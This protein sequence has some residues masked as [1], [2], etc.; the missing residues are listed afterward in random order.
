MDLLRLRRAG[1][2]TAVLAATSCFL[3]L[4]S[5]PM[6]CAEEAGGETLHARIQEAIRRGREELLRSYPRKPGG[7]R[8]DYPMGRTALPLAA[9]LR[10]GIPSTHPAIAESFRA[11][12]SLPPQ[13][14]YSA[15]C[16]LIALDALVQAR[17]REAREEASKTGTTTR[18]I[19]R[20]IA[21]D[22]AVRARMEQVIRW[23]LSVRNAGAGT[24][25]YRGEGGH[26]YSNTQFAV[27]GLSIGLAHRIAIPREVFLEIARQFSSPLRERAQ[28]EFA[29]TYNPSP[30]AFLTRTGSTTRTFRRPLGGWGYTQAE[31]VAYASMTAAGASDL[32]VAQ[33]ALGRLGP[34]P[35][36]A[37]DGALGWI[38]VN[39]DQ[40]LASRRNY[41]YALYSLEKV[42]DLGDIAAF[43]GRDWYLEGAS[44]ILERQAPGGGWGDSIDTSFALLFLTRATR[45]ALRALPA[46]RVM[47]LAG[48]EGSGDLVHVEAIGG[49]ISAR[50]FFEYLAASGDPSLLKIAAEVA[51]G[52]PLSRQGEMVPW[53]LELWAAPGDPIGAFARK[54][55]AMA[56][57][58]AYGTPEEY[59]RWSTAY[60]AI[61]AAEE[62]PRKDSRRVS[63][64][65]SGAPGLKLK[66][67]V[68]E[69]IS[70]A[71]LAE[72]I[73]AL[74]EELRA[75]D[76]PYRARVAEVLARL[77]GEAPSGL[78]LEAA[79]DRE[80]AV[81][82]WHVLWRERGA[83]IIAR[84]RIR[85]LIAILRDEAGGETRA[86][87]A[88]SRPTRER[89]DPDEA[90]DSLAGEG[91]AAVPQI[92][93]AMS[94]P[95]FP[96]RLV[97]A[98]ERISGR[99]LGLRPATWKAWWETAG[100]A[101]GSGPGG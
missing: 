80:A 16:Y 23:L 53:L 47:T 25:H 67:L 88:A 84:E 86:V 9:L 90:L 52:Y 7:G 13:E 76:V 71:S 82:A 95:E 22:G 65:L 74:I 87:A 24:W 3:P 62:D 68:V 92:L 78:G 77:A 44:R 34:G 61:R 30:K 81:A 46:P 15:S 36:D 48:G 51:A 12:E 11:L 4:L 40:F 100:K 69:L 91:S 54:S 8:G 6:E 10:A 43:D 66:G 56:T 73:P 57:G 64:L 63:E 101:A 70:R 60:R 28:V 35:Q 29:I 98:L 58:E 72:S 79:G 49:Y 27:L 50:E 39:L 33:E 19:P 89:G 38:A 17:A 83:S 14:V 20:R 55:L 37:L 75:S 99:K 93:E 2:P 96:A 1:K 94:R 42:G 59:E 85:K 31:K 26:D 5:A 21:A 18:A 97:I 45:P 32:L 41:Y